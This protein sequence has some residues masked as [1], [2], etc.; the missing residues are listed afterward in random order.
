MSRG[1]TR[2]RPQRVALATCAAA[3][4]VDEHDR[5]LVPALQALGVEVEAA[6]WDDRHVDWASF[7]IV[8]LRATWD[9][10]D[11]PQEFFDWMDRA[12]SSGPQV[13][14]RPSVVRWNTDKRFLAALATT[15]V[16]V[17]PTTFIEPGEPV[18]LPTSGEIVV[19]PAISA[20]SRDTARYDATTDVMLSVTHVQGLLASGRTVMV[21][22]YIDTVDT[23]GESALIYLGGRYSHAV[24]KG[25]L[26]QRGAR[27]TEG[28]FLQEDID[29]HDATPAELSVAETVMRGLPQHCQD[30]L[31]ARV[32]LLHTDGGPVLLELEL[33]EPSLFLGHADN[34]AAERLAQAI[35]SRLS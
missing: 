19:K 35:V 2:P 23:H 9:Y 29:R 22:P 18:R 21:Q 10:H 16:A 5:P 14:N 17:V 34:G 27:P 1:R 33:T 3:P 30:L 13:W 20:G 31:Y 12:E 15:D 6:V 32:D 26:L 11:R 4:E 8:V 28:L 24:R 25:P 7:G